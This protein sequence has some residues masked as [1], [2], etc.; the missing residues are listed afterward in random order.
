MTTL[1]AVNEM[2]EWIEQPPV[3]EL[4]TGGTSDEAEAERTLDRI[5]KEIQMRSDGRGWYVNTEE[6]SLGVPDTKIA[7]SGV[8]GTFSYGETVTQS[9]SGATGTFDHILSGFMYLHS[10]SG[11]FVSGPNT[12]TGGTSAATATAGAYTAITESRIALNPDELLTV[13]PSEEEGESLRIVPRG[14]FFWDTE[15]GTYTFDESLEITIVRMLDIDEM[16]NA[17]ASHIVKEAAWNFMRYKFPGRVDSE[18]RQLE[19]RAAKA[20]AWNEDANLR[21]TNVLETHEARRIKGSRN[22]YGGDPVRVV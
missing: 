1:E 17:L 15:D 4:D 12:L 5:S 3:D 19:R 7:V 14:E 2:L 20:A 16:T 10:V 21:R 11:T 18:A 9:G 13:L 8:T 22:R 6:L